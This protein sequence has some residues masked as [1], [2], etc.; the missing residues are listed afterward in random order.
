MRKAEYSC[1]WSKEAEHY[2][3]SAFRKPPA[4]VF[5]SR[6]QGRQHSNFVARAW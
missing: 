2:D 1:M 4:V 5:T 3:P 6:R